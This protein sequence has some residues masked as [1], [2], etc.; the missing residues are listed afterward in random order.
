MSTFTLSDL[1]KEMGPGLGLRKNKYLIEIPV[2]G[3]SGRKINILCRSTSLPERNIS[4]IDVYDKGRRY[5]VRGE[6]DFPGVYNISILD[7]SEMNIRKLF[8][9]WINLVDNTKPRDDGILGALGNNFTQ[10]AEA[11]SGVINAFNTLKSSFEMDGGLSFIL[12]GI[13]G[14]PGTVNYQ[15][16]VNVWQLDAKNNKIYGYQLQNAFPTTVGTVE[17]DDGEENSLSEFSVDFTY[18]E[19]IPLENKTDFETVTERLLGTAG[20]EVVNGIRNL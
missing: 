17:L 3:V 16:D 11:I 7:D 1:K 4:T 18:S 12:N 14:N 13:D 8:D 2:P 19:F 9:Q 15:T 5:K 10:A 6:T 20:T